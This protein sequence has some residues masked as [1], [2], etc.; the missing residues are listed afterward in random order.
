MELIRV[1]ST[2]ILPLKAPIFQYDGRH[3]SPTT[4]GRPLTLLQPKLTG[5]IFAYSFQITFEPVVVRAGA[6][7]NAFYSETLS[8]TSRV[9][10]WGSV[11]RMP[12]LTHLTTHLT[13]PERPQT[14]AFSVSTDRCREHCSVCSLLGARRPVAVHGCL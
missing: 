3:D 4:C 1:Y 8:T 2:N 11:T 12:M 9:F 5:N 6:Y 10:S 14:K 7:I 13:F